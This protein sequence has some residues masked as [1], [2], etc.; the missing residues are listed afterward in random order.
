MYL[1]EIDRTAWSKVPSETRHRQ[2]YLLEIDRTAWPKGQFW[3]VPAGEPQ[4]L[5]SRI[6]TTP[7]FARVGDDADFRSDPTIHARIS[8]M[9]LVQ[10]TPSNYTGCT[11]SIIVAMFNIGASASSQ[12]VEQ[13]AD[14]A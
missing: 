2:M 13:P 7:K 9:T 4:D 3:R 12:K 10:A 14:L 5:K 11:R 6:S 1:L 8:R